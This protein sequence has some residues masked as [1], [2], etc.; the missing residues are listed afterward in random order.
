VE[1]IKYMDT[2]HHCNGF[3]EQFASVCDKEPDPEIK[4]LLEK[5]F[6]VIAIN[7]YFFDVILLLL[8]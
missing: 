5:E 6:K 4:S 1:F 8:N 2:S 3:I 7:V